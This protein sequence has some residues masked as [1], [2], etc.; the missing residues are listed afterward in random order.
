MYRRIPN[1]IRWEKK[2][3]PCYPNLRKYFIIQKTSFSKAYKTCLLIKMKEARAE[4][5][6]S[7]IMTPY[8]ILENK[9]TELYC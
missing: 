9:P 7:A 6:F 3:F 4:D 8:F 5:F 2:L 1:E